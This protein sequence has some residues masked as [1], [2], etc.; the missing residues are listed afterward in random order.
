[1]TEVDWNVYH[2]N[3]AIE[4]AGMSVDESVQNAAIIVGRP[5]RTQTAA[6]INGFPMGVQHT[7]ARWERP[8]KYMWVEHAERNAIYYAAQ[9][10]IKTHGSTM[11]CPWAACHDCARAIV[12]AGISKLVRLPTGEH[13]G[14]NES[15]AIGEIILR[16]G[17]VQ[18]V[19]IP[20]DKVTI[21]LGTRLGQFR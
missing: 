10:G 6:G 17:G 3:I 5:P 13:E 9:R 8:A 18:I 19:E 12:Q 2:M 15:I 16:E 7:P 21:P 14:W 20:I 11:Y 4:T 1:M